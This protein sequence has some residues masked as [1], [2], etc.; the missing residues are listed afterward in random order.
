MNLA[1]HAIE[2]WDNESLSLCI[3]PCVGYVHVQYVYSVFW[4]TLNTKES[5]V[6]QL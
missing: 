1:P 6:F 5:I 3:S 2:E 4:T